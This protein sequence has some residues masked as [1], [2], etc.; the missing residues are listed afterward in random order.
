M[1]NQKTG[2]LIQQ[3]A[4]TP[5]FDFGAIKQVVDRHV[6]NYDAGLE[7]R[8]LNHIVENWDSIPQRIKD[9]KKGNAAA[10]KAKKSMDTLANQTVAAQPKETGEKHS[11]R[12]SDIENREKN[13]YSSRYENRFFPGNVFPTGQTHTSV[14]EWAMRKEVKTG[15]KRLV[16]HRGAYYRVEKFDDMDFKYL[17]TKKYDAQDYNEELREY[18]KTDSG[19]SVQ[20]RIDRVDALYRESDEYGHGRYHAGSSGAEYGGENLPL[21]SVDQDSTEGRRDPAPFS[22]INWETYMYACS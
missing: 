5:T 22:Q 8:A 3:K 15:D 4:V 20:E 9:L 1:V 7:S 17:I 16:L 10:K 6:Q 19:E 21:L 18:G 13:R 11:D 12:N 14:A 2:K